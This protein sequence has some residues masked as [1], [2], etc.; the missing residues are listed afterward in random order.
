MSFL[1]KLML[2]KQLSFTDGKV[3]L[4]E[5]R[6][7]FFPSDF[8]GLYTKEII[9]DFNMVTTLYKSLKQ[10]AID[11]FGKK[12]LKSHGFSIIDYSKMIKDIAN[13]SGWGNIAFESFDEYNKHSIINIEDSPIGSY[14]QGK[15]KTPCDH[16]LRGLIAGYGTVAFE[17]DVDAIE[18]ECTALGSARCKIVVDS[19]ENLKIKF[20]EYYKMQIENE[21]TG[22][23]F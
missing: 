15:V 4:L 10:T 9:D 6:V 5:Q 2:S 19:P 16:I 7:L 18:I 13:L 3:E 21:E 1:E 8:F 17:H 22:D 20:P 12:T 14:L 23:L 11:G